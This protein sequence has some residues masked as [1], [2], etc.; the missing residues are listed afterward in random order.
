MFPSILTDDKK[1]VYTVFEMPLWVILAIW[2]L[3]RK[4][5]KATP[6]VDKIDL[7][8]FLEYGE[9]LANTRT[10]SLPNGNGWLHGKV[11]AWIDRQQDAINA[12]YRAK[13]SNFGCV[14]SDN[15]YV[16]KPCCDKDACNCDS[17]VERI[18]HDLT[19]TE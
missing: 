6:K 8:A 3:R 13:F 11:S 14:D 5:G 16:V 4:A 17:K 10:Y 2:F 12:L 15:F 7:A 18:L 19:K 9:V 1:P